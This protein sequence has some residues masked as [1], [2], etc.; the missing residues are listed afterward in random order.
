MA[1]QYNIHE[2][3]TNLSKLLMRVAKGEE[4]II[5][6]SGIPIAKLIPLEKEKKQNRLPG[7]AKGKITMFNNFTE[8]LPNDIIDTFHK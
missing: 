7:S 2:A 5:A 3:K 8:P 4:I 6:K 1:K